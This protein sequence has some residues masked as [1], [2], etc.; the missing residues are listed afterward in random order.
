[1]QLVEIF[2]QEILKNLEKDIFEGKCRIGFTN[3]SG[4]EYNEALK[5]VV[6]SFN[7]PLS[8]LQEK[9]Y[10]DYILITASKFYAKNNKRLNVEKSKI[11]IYPSA[12]DGLIHTDMNKDY[13]TTITFLNSHWE[14]TWGGEI[15]CYSD[16][17]K[18]VL[19]G[20]TPQFGK[21]FA[22]NGKIPHRAVAPIRLSALQRVVL[23]TKEKV[24][25][26]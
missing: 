8:K 21:T 6:E 7:I 20:V 19:G 9:D 16:D 24:E 17:L 11:L 26:N 2:D 5:N 4:S 12:H 15:L 3:A 25:S 14:P 18:V 23:V 10:Y 13:L 22:F 1:M